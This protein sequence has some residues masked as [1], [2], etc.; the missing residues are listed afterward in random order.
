VLLEDVFGDNWVSIMFVGTAPPRGVFNE[1]GAHL[2]GNG[3]TGRILGTL[4]IAVATCVWL[5][6]IGINQLEILM[7][8]GR[9]ISGTLTR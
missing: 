1:F 9:F 8:P 7:C 4:F 2:I 3:P 6:D 5:Q